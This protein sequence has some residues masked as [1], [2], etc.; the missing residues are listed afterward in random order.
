MLFT[1]GFVCGTTPVH[2]LLLNWL[3]GFDIRSGRHPYPFD[4]HFEYVFDKKNTRMY[5]IYV[6]LYPSWSIFLCFP[7]TI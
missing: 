7:D 6:V 3:N 1:K 5:K 2:G 4:I